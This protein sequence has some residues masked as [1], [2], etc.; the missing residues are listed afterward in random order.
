VPRGGQARASGQG[1][2]KDAVAQVEF[3]LAVDGQ[4]TVAVDGYAHE[5]S[6]PRHASLE[7]VGVQRV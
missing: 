7:S 1:A 2:G 4:I 5:I 6:P 3:D